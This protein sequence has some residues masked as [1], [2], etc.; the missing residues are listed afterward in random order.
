MKAWTR[1][2]TLGMG[3]ALA[4]SACGEP[5]GASGSAKARDDAAAPASS[6]KPTLATATATATAAAQASGSPPPTAAPTGIA[7]AAPVPSARPKPAQPKLEENPFVDA[8]VE[9]LSTFAI[10]VDTASYTLV[11]GALASGVRP[12]PSSVRIEEMINYFRFSY[13]AP[14]NAAFG[15]MA[16]AGRAPWAED[17][18]LVRIGIKGRELPRGVRP[19]TNLVLLVD[20]SGSMQGPTKMGLLKHGFALLAEQLDERDSVAIVS[21]AGKSA[22]V[23]PPTRG[24]RHAVIIN[25]LDKIEAGGMTNGE[26]GMKQAYELAGNAYI[27]GGINRVLLATDGDFNLGATKKADLEDFIALKAR[28]GIYLS[29]LGFGRYNVNDSTME[30]LADKGNGNYAFID[31]KAEAKRVLVDQVAGTLATIAK[32]VKIQVSWDPSAVK[33]YRLIGYENRKLAAKDFTDDSKD[34][35]EIGSGHTV[36]ALYDVVPVSQSNNGRIW[37]R[38]TLRYKTPEG[39]DSSAVEGDIVGSDARFDELSTDFRFASAVAGFGMLLR[40]SAFK[41]DL[42]Y[43]KVERIARGALGDDADERRAELADLVV[44]AKKLGR[45]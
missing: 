35:G 21:Y 45:R 4:A 44:K 31:G 12:A 40:G 26:Q 38:L 11:R 29:V 16:D 5:G 1:W 22:V 9:R 10:D 19:A 7:S 13:P 43:D 2:V 37:G 3:I 42:D 17:H 33:S 6:A 39:R 18:R 34:G 36:T 20:A 23:L 30:T 25:A 28:T 27:Q 8:S 32:D 24:D 15:F 41:G 14:P